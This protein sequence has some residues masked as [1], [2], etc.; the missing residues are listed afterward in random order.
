VFTIAGTAGE[1]E[2]SASSQTITVGLPTNVTIAGNL[3]VDTNTLFVDAT[4]NRVGIGTA[5]PSTIIDVNGDTPVLTLRDSRVGGT[6]S[7]GTALGKLD[8]YTS[9]TTGIGPHSIASIG[10]EAGG[11]NTASPDGELVFSTGAYNTAASEKMRIDSS[12]NVGIG[13]A[14]PKTSLHV[15]GLS[16]PSSVPAAGV[17]P[18]VSASLYLTNGDPAYGITM[19]VLNIGD[20]YIQ[21][22]RTAD[23]ATTYD[24]LLN[25]NGGNV[26]IGTDSPGTVFHVQSGSANPARIITSSVTNSSLL[27]GNT[28]TGSAVLTLDGA[29]GD[30]A[31]ADYFTIQQNNDLTAN[32]YTQ[33]SAGVLT[34][35]SKGTS[36]AITIDGANVG[37]GK[38]AQIVFCVLKTPATVIPR[39]STFTVSVFQ[40]QAQLV[41]QYLL[42]VIQAIMMLRCTSNHSLLAHNPV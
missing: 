30:A 17:S 23:S 4:N 19:G 1:I 26:G 6:W 11:Q 3:T 41:D 16:S 29:N 42:I 2:T 10:V 34:L 39:G 27:I 21:A 15:Q 32:I 28:S 38:R 33:A 20:G 35:G 7:A 22:Q 31:G 18:G 8:F 37:I 5:S 36:N 14:S 24:L 9:D 25:P 12:G 40:E 13:T